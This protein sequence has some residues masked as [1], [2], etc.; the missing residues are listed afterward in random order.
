MNS[1]VLYVNCLYVLYRCYPS[2]FGKWFIEAITYS[3]YLLNYNSFL[4]PILE[5]TRRLDMTA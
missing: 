5:L 2:A 1:P 3:L 4:K